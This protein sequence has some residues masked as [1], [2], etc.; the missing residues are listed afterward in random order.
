MWL[1][2]GFSGLISMNKLRRPIPEPT[3]KAKGTWMS[4]PLD[5]LFWSAGSPVVRC[6]DGIDGNAAKPSP[7]HCPFPSLPQQQSLSLPF[8][9]VFRCLCHKALFMF[10]L[11]SSNFLT[12]SAF[13]DS[14]L[15]LQPL[16]FL[17]LM[18]AAFLNLKLTLQLKSKVYRLEWCTC[19]SIFVDLYLPVWIN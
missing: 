15:F 2:E 1:C 5:V 12:I 19:W 13:H 4:S 10:S 6:F 11:P 3:L 17:E 18:T 16:F 9:L 8:R 14:T 7:I